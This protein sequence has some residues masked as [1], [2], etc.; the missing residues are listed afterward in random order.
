MVQKVSKNNKLL[1]INKIFQEEWVK[2]NSFLM[3]KGRWIIINNNKD[4]DKKRKSRRDKINRNIIKKKVFI[5][6]HR[7]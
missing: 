6:A 1:R 3:Y 7:I 2:I 4:K 5:I